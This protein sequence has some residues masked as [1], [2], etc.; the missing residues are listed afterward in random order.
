MKDRKRS[1][2]CGDGVPRE[3]LSA[4]FPFADAAMRAAVTINVE[5]RDDGDETWT[6]LTSV[7]PTGPGLT[8]VF[9]MG[10]KQLY[11]FAIDAQ[12]PFPGELI[13]VQALRPTWGPS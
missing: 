12:G 13:R 3:G 5:H 8:T 1:K 10:I 7:G 9:A 11:R 2:R 4:A 6:T